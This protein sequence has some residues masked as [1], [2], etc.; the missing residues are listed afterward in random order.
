[1]K[2]QDDPPRSLVEAFLLVEQ[3]R[4]RISHWTQA[5]AALDS[6]NA[7]PLAAV[8]AYYD[9]IADQAVL[10]LRYD[11]LALGSARLGYIVEVA[12]LAEVGMIQPAE[13]SDGERARFLS[14]RL[15]RCTL[16]VTYARDVVG[17]LAELVRRIK[18][19]RGGKV[20]SQPPPLPLAKGTRDDL[21]RSSAR[22]K[23]EP[24]APP[25]LAPPPTSR[26][27]VPRRMSSPRLDG[28][29]Y[30]PATAIAPKDMI[31]ARYLR[32]GRWVP[33]RI[34]AL[35]LKGAALMSGALPRLHD[36]VDVALSYG[37]HRALVRG[38]V[39]KVSTD[40]EAAATGA[41]T[42]SVQFELDSSSRQQLTQ[43][44]SAARAANVTI[45]PAPARATRRFPV[46]LPLC[47]GT[48]RG[49]IKADAL[50]VSVGGMFVRSPFVLERG[51]VVSFS[52]A[53]D[54]DRGQIAGRA[55]IVRHIADSMAKAC[56]VS[57]G[58]GLGIV[59]MSDADRA[60]WSAFLARVE[61]RSERRIL[62]GATQ[63]RLAELQA[64]LESCGY[65]VM[66]GTD[67][68]AIV[69]LARASDRPVDAALFDAGWLQNGASSSWVESLFSAR[70]I[71]CATALGDGRR[72]RG[73]IDR[74]LDV[75]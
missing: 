69:Q 18:D 15:A 45:K 47:V 75:V 61:R 56:G 3:P 6:P 63:A 65:V 53:L 10:Q 38:A 25:Q 28:E 50:D 40:T 21:R 42:F 68:G 31:F 72:G 35:S 62:V 73:A 37:A 58:Y 24:E 1:M 55:R 32:G 49:A 20:Q 41:S 19:T 39:G 8:H 4:Q 16:H 43:L 7:P 22:A 27:V 33:I 52:M 11:E 66:G 57:A 23:R 44:L 54:D 29:A 70:G 51:T 13:L 48:T 59:E 74:M 5:L 71:P 30:V 9:S 64:A 34:G 60:R 2:V 17:A 46:E 12:L 14:E 67:P 36:R 26:H